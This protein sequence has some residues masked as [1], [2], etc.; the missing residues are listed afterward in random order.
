MIP[1]REENLK[2]AIAYFSSEF[3]SRKKYFPRQTWI[4]KFLTLLDF[5]M[6][7]KTGVPCIG[8]EYNA[9]KYGPV[10]PLLYDARNEL[11]TDKYRFVTTSDGGSKV[12]PLDEPDLDY[13]SD[14]EL[15]VMDGILDAY[16]QDDVDLE[17]L[18]KDAHKEIK[19]WKKAW[20]IAEKVGRGK[21]PMEYEDEFDD[22]FQKA[23]EDLTPEEERFLCYRDIAAMEEA[24]AA[25]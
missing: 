7:K 14:N 17:T 12:E 13:F 21:I 2:N 10:P 11:K 19:A 25:F 4:Y 9:M 20:A 15:D 6:L 23:E 3:Y 18:I 5:R 1:Y 8:L 24:E 16:T 22:L